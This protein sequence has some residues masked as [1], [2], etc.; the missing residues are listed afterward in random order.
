MTCEI[1]VVEVA[2]LDPE[3]NT[4]WT[5]E[6]KAFLDGDE[7]NRYMDE[8]LAAGKGA[9]LQKI[10]AA[11]SLYFLVAK[12]QSEATTAKTVPEMLNAQRENIHQTVGT[13]VLALAALSGC[14]PVQI[15]TRN[16]PACAR[17]RLMGYW[18]TARMCGRAW[19]DL[20]RAWGKDHSTVMSGCRRFQA[21]LNRR[22]AWA[23]ELLEAWGVAQG[24]TDLPEAVA[25]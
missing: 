5:S 1:H 20:G 24:T 17:V 13:V 21:E 11:G 2:K 3:G 4:V 19:S 10:K 22:E 6:A 18:I 25:S 12:A 15:R 14:S 8:M 9:K 16:F 7:A 23:V